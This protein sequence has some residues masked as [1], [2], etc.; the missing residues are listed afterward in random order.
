M[1]IVVVANPN[2][3]TTV[4]EVREVVI[5]A[6]SSAGQLTVVTT[7]HQGHAT[8]A[9]AHALDVGADAVVAYGGDGT[10]NEVLQG[11]LR[12]G[13]AATVPALGI[14]PGGSANVFARNLGLPRD[15]VFAAGRALRAL[16]HGP[17]TRHVSLGVADERWFAF[18]AGMGLD[19]A[20]VDL[21]EQARHRGKRATPA[22]YVRSAV[23]AFFSTDRA[24]TPITVTL[25]DGSRRGPLAL[26]LVTNCAPWTYLG[27]VQANPTP[28]ASFDAGLDLVGLTGLSVARTI[29]HA[30]A[31]TL[32]SRGA[33]GRD[34][35]A[36]HDQPSYVLDA[37]QPMP[38][39]I[40][41]EYL[42]LRTSTRLRSVPDAV[43]V[44]V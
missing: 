7:T 42:G 30:A 32:T 22:R 28:R 12:D 39:Q 31:I 6:L 34:V 19:A 2:A 11:I 21:V 15:P 41:G 26:A 4:P 33:R 25:A 20:V 1:H 36:L 37:T 16:R 13:P 43:R 14:I 9:G 40:D 27:P 23:R 8:E 44:L 18:N 10:V 3:T 29:G 38:T 17:R 24:E 35:V 5:G